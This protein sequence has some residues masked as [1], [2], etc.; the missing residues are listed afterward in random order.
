M[1]FKAYDIRG[2]YPSEI[3]EQ[4]AYN[5]GRTIGKSY[6][7]VLFGIDSRVG[8]DRIKDYFIT[9]IK[10]SK[11]KIKFAGIISTPLLYFLTKDAFD[12]GVIA[13]ASHNPKEFTGFKLCG[14]NGIPLSPNKD[15][16]PNFIDYPKPSK[17]YSSE[18]F[19]K[20]FGKNYMNY[21]FKKFNDLNSENNIVIDYSN[22]STI[23]EKKIIES[24]FPKAQFIGDEIDGNF[25]NHAP[26][27]MKK[28]CLEMLIDKVTR[29][30]ADVGIIFDGDGDR[31]GIIDEKGNIIPGDILSCIILSELLKDQKNYFV[32]YDLR[33]SHIVPET[34][35]ELGGIPLKTR[36]GHY[37]IK[38]IMKEKG[39]IFA[40]ELSNHF[41][42]KEIGGFEAPLLA[43]YYLLKSLRANKLS[44]IASSYMKYFHSGEINFK[45]KDQKISINAFLKQ[46]SN[47]KIEYIDGITIEYDNWWANVR[48]SNTE[49]LLRVNIEA[50]DR[51]T[52]KSK[53]REIEDIF[54]DKDEISEIL[55]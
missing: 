37:Y 7:N 33:C 43:L 35:I 34:I 38:N 27:T 24:I 28:E 3:N 20:D 25:P 21:Y 30:N 46:Y 39:A 49:P 13:T 11:A 16:K 52:L 54:S 12:M 19:R 18:S 29:T 22:G 15:I 45:V 14:I 1:V 36:V 8:S 42:F 40:G 53:I 32:L 47:A 6:K 31:I 55:C 44:K 26:D 9:G 41:Y 17:I 51:I 48:P 5:L 50:K 2:K 10:E 4:F 23:Y